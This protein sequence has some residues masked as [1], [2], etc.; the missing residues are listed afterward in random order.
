MCSAN[1]IL[2]VVVFAWTLMICACS[3]DSSAT[4]ELDGPDPQD[5]DAI[6][7]LLDYHT[8]DTASD[9]A[10]I[11]SDATDNSDDDSAD[12]IAYDTVADIAADGM[13]EMM[14]DA[15]SS[16]RECAFPVALSD[17]LY[18]YQ[19]DHIDWGDEGMIFNYN[20]TARDLYELNTILWGPLPLNQA[21]GPQR[22]G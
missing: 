13:A 19:P 22:P 2:A 11:S 10:D 9:A 15:L 1:R 14:A 7:D 5:G 21:S 17:H 8:P 4:D 6:S 16:V 12:P 18:D 3:E 20:I